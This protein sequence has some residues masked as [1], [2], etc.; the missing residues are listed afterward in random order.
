MI[1]SILEVASWFVMGRGYIGSGNRA[2]VMMMGWAELLLFLEPLDL[3][4]VNVHLQIEIIENHAS[5]V[6]I[7][8]SGDQV[9]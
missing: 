8:V 1:W 6:V 4:L 3:I 9:R 7:D 5:L 2:C